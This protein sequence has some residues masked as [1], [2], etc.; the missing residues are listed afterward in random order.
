MARIGIK[1]KLV[2]H[3]VETYYNEEGKIIGYVADNCVEHDPAKVQEHLDNIARI[4]AEAE[5]WQAMQKAGQT[6][7]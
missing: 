2:P 7:E 3:I 4:W 1:P 6:T 5:A